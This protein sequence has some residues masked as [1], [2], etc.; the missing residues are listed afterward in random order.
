MK[1]CL[2]EYDPLKTSNSRGTTIESTEKKRHT[3]G[4]EHIRENRVQN[5]Q[6]GTFP[7]QIQ[8]TFQNGSKVKIN[9]TTTPQGVLEYEG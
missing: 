2:K 5:Y 4:V 1:V 9:I 8:V 7:S 6:K 3:Q